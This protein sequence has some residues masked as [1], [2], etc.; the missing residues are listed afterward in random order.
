MQI[1]DVD[2]V[3]EVE[4]NA[5]MLIE[6]SSDWI[7]RNPTPTPEPVIPPKAELEILQ[8][9]VV[10]VETIQSEVIDTLAIITGVTIGE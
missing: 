7:T 8:E 2:G 5:R 9:Q 6:P 3:W 1:T 4:G 10:T